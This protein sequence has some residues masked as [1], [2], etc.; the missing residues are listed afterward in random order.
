MLRTEAV[1]QGGPTLN[2]K[3]RASPAN[4]ASD[5]EAPT[6]SPCVPWGYLPSATVALPLC[7]PT[8]TGPW[9]IH[10]QHAGDGP[11]LTRAGY[12]SRTPPQGGGVFGAL[13]SPGRSTHPS[14]SEKRAKNEIYQRGRKLEADFG[15]KTFFL[16]SDPPPPA[17]PPPPFSLSNSLDTDPSSK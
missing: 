15:Y 5:P 1:R 2:S 17:P 3:S 13:A 16:A 11:S 8:R 9:Q 6:A 10:I 7:S 4:A 12:C 14:T